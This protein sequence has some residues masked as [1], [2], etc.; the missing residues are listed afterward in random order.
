MRVKIHGGST[1]PCCHDFSAPLNP[2]GPPPRLQDIVE[3]CIARRVHLRYP[4]PRLQGLRERLAD[5][6]RLD[7]QQVVP[8]NGAAEALALLP[9]LLGARRLVVVEP[10]FGDHA[11][12]AKA[13]GIPLLRVAWRQWP[14]PLGLL[15]EAAGERGVVLV[16][17]PVNPTGALPAAGELEEL[18]AMLWRRGGHLVVDEAFIDLSPGAEPLE[19]GP[20]LVVV[21]SMTK[22]F[23]TP[24]LR[25]GYVAA[26]PGLAERIWMAL[27]AWPVGGLEECVYKSLL[28]DER[29]RWHVSTARLL[30]AEEEPRLRA[31][32]GSLGLGAGES[33][34]PFLL[35][36]HPWLPH[37]WMGRLLARHGVYVR[38]ASSFHGLGPGHSRVSIRTVGENDALIEAMRRVVRDA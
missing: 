38:D 25:L 20:G 2:L 19:P 32:L 1:P 34:A 6:H 21:R 26:E 16:S 13:W 5:W 31:A 35:L 12:H 24:G 14:L 27:Q 11:A 23:A 22:T 10:C 9:P 30:V 33:R 36:S 8:L 17:R 7:P 28:A 4:H 29:S 18:A 15:A 3:E 37:P